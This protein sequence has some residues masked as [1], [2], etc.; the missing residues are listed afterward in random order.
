MALM[1]IPALVF[2]CSLFGQSPADRPV[3]P[4]KAEGKVP[5]ALARARL[6]AARRTFDYLARNYR[7]ARPPAG[8]LVYRWSRRWLK[9]ERDLAGTPAD[10]VAAYQ[11][12][13]ARMRD[14]ER[15]ARDRARER[16]VPLEEATAAE[17]YRLEA[18]IWLAQVKEKE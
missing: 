2:W 8:E 14:L 13:L 9:A 3:P 17:Y 18:E 7:E 10:R 11:A 1:A 15:V 5:A 4:E 6:D 12:H 16:F